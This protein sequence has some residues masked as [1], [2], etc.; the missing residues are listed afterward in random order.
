MSS[1]ARWHFTLSQA[2]AGRGLAV[3]ACLCVGACSA[4][5]TRFDFPA[6]NVAENNAP[7]GA[8]PGSPGYA[9]RPGQNFE[10]P[11][12]APPRGVGAVDAPPATVYGGSYQGE[13]LASARDGQPQTAPL[14]PL[15][16]EHRAAPQ[17]DAA[18]APERQRQAL[19]PDVA[20]ERA[21]LARRELAPQSLSTPA[22]GDTVQ[23]E[24]GDTLYG[25][26]KRY[27]VALADLID[28]N[29]L[30]H[31]ASLKPGQQIVLPAGTLARLARREARAKP[32]V[33]L[34]PVAKVPVAATAVDA[35]PGAAPP[36]APTASPPAPAPAA[37]TA[38]APAATGWEGRYTIKA[39]ESLYGIA[40]QHRVSL[41][42]L[43]RVNGIDNPMRVKVGTTLQVPGAAA[44]TPAAEPAPARELAQE[45]PATPKIINAPS[46]RKVVASRSD[47]VSDAD[48]VA[49]SAA[50]SP[51]ASE[52]ASG[53]FRWPARG[54]VIAG[55]GRRPDGTQNDGINLALPQGA[56]VHA[57]E[58]GKVA[59]AG[60]ELKGYG[61]LIL[62][63]H[64]NGWVSAYAHNDQLLVKRDDVVRRGQVIAKAGK[65][66]SVDQPQLH[67]ELRQGSRPVDPMPHLEKNQ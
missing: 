28:A 9:Q 24:Q 49:A 19:A 13:R 59:Y 15:V 23:V 25:L 38:S 12:G 54:R 42:E 58:A 52:A 62:I 40:R 39:G 45:T 10:V 37:A 11:P 50:A 17:N 31:G 32:S 51:G 66:G 63:R 65:T 46:E 7:T 61:N 48:P 44:A 16:P 56:E 14:P 1:N 18:Y 34:V 47:Q 27:G 35:N 41:A 57:S 67:F 20:P 26:S 29:R 5:V 6:F 21:V 8:L 30:H 55:Y 60:N 36:P 2:H 43:Q 33:A 64:D 4:D 3:A 53:R 22:R